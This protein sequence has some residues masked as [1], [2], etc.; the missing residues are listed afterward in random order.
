MRKKRVSPK[1]KKKKTNLS[2]FLLFALLNAKI[3]CLTST[4][5]DIGSIPFWLINTN[6]FGFSFESVAWS[7]TRF[8]SSTIFFSLASTKRRSDSTS[9][10]LWAADE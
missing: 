6:V 9:F 10:S 2:M 7:H 1:K 4:S 5:S 3:P 8:L